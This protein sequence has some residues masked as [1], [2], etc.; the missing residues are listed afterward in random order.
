MGAVLVVGP[1][2]H[3]FFEMSCRFTHYVLGKS[4]A[5]VGPHAMNRLSQICNFIR[6]KVLSHRIAVCVNG[7]LLYLYESYIQQDAGRF[8]RSFTVKET[9]DDAKCCILRSV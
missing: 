7:K 1:Q 6:D 5:M 4:R 9:M 3:N 8:R 2:Q